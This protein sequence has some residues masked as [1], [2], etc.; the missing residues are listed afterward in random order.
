MIGLL[1]EPFEQRSQLPI[2]GIRGRYPP[3]VIIV[4]GLGHHDQL[5]F[6]R[7]RGGIFGFRITIASL[8]TSASN[9]SRR[10]RSNS[11]SGGLTASGFGSGGMVAIVR[12]AETR[13]RE[14]NHGRIS[15]RGIKLDRDPFAHFQH[16]QLRLGLER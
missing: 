1:H 10:K 4:D 9:A 2:R 14:V 16:R 3:R 11:F 8:R 7:G 15:W 13:R 6:F 12:F 5:G